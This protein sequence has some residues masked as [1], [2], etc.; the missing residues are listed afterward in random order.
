MCWN[1]NAESAIS[2]WN[3]LHGMGWTLF[4]VVFGVDSPSRGNARDRI[5]GNSS[6]GHLLV[7]SL[8]NLRSA[9]CYDDDDD[10]TLRDG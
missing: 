4:V 9:L 10:D 6:N 1:V 2:Q 5:Q 8:F 3:G 7:S